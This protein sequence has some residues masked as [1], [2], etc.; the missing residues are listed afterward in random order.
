MLESPST[1]KN[2]REFSSIFRLV[3]MRLVRYY[4]QT[5]LKV[6]VPREPIRVPT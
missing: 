1:R 2:S 5:Q 6:V 3:R 4:T